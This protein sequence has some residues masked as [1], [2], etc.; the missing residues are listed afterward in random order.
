MSFHC[1]ESMNNIA[2]Y[3][4]EGKRGTAFAIITSEV[5][6]IIHGILARCCAFR[7]TMG[8]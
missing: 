4:S 7:V 5:V 2:I 8:F 6:V 3:I 1:M